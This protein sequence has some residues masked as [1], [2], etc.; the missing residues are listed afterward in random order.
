[1][2]D[3][4]KNI[5]NFALIFAILLHVMFKDIYVK[6]IICSIRTFFGK[7]QLLL[8]IRN[9]KKTD[10][11]TW[12][13]INRFQL[14]KDTMPP[15]ID[16]SKATITM[17]EIATALLYVNTTT[18]EKYLACIST[19]RGRDLLREV[20]NNPHKYKLDSKPSSIVDKRLLII[21]TINDDTYSRDNHNAE[22][23]PQR[24]W[25]KLQKVT[26]GIV[27][28]LVV[29]ILGLAFFTWA[30]REEQVK[31]E[32][33]ALK[34]SM[35]QIE[36][37]TFIMGSP[38]NEEGRSSDEIQHT[39]TLTRPF[40][41]S[42]T[43]VTQG[44]WQAVIG[45]NPSQFVDCGDGCPVE[46]VSWNDAVEFCNKL[47]HMEGLTPCYTGSG[48]MI[49]WDRVCTGYRLPTEAEWE[50]AARAGDTGARYGDLKAVGWYDGNS[51]KMPH[52]VGSKQANAW[53]LYD[54]LGNVWEWTWDWYG[55]YPL[56]SV[57]DP[58]GPN[59]GTYWVNRGGSWFVIAMYCRAAIRNGVGPD[60]RFSN[61][62]FRIARSFVPAGKGD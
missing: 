53:G 43:E 47:S 52:P 40:L 55:D 45:S 15:N 23:Q 32:I 49:N 26:V 2:S 18:R 44:Q 22:E 11:A 33:E 30:R 24:Q 60:I 25:S 27:V 37:G 48:S 9:L 8:F 13:K 41:M 59:S 21:N 5:Y 57:S 17:E 42:K 56:G 10:F 1:M 28:A 3:F 58:T 20:I 12:K 19:C 38:S 4:Y 51:G 7:L 6:F 54:M 34:K 14:S 29:L 62:G 35:T 61:L 39:V 50:Y 46:M 31:D 16:W 36:P